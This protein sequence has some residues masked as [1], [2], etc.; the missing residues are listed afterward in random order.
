MTIFTSLTIWG[1]WYLKSS[2][3]ITVEARKLI[4]TGPFKFIRHP[5]YFGELMTALFVCIWRFS[6]MNLGFYILLVIIQLYRSNLEQKK[7]AKN[8]PD[9]QKIMMKKWWFF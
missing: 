6:W 4:T 2:F 8:F 9:Y 7:L 5:I 1:M 3:S